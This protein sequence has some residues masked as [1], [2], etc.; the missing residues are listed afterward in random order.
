[1]SS[2]APSPAPAAPNA[3]ALDASVRLARLRKQMFAQVETPRIAQ[4]HVLRPLGGGGMGLVFAAWD[5]SLDRVI[6][7]KVLRD[8]RSAKSGKQL[9]REAIALA[10]LRHPNVVSVFEVGDHRG[11]VY[12]AMEYVEG[13][14][15][16]AWVR[17][18]RAARRRD[19]DALLDVFGQAC[20]G[21][22]AAHAADLVHRDVK[23][24][25]VMIDA[26]GRVRLMDFGLARRDAPDGATQDS[27]PIVSDAALA[28]PTLTNTVG[29]Q[30]TPAYMAPEQFDGDPPGPAADQFALCACLFEA[31]VGRSA[32]PDRMTAA[33]VAAETPVEFPS[34]W[35]GPR[36]LQAILQRGLAQDP[37]A[38]F[39]S[40]E[41]L[42]EQLARLRRRSTGRTVA[43]AGLGVGLVATITA[44]TW[45]SRA[46]SVDPCAHAGDA[47][48]TTYST[49]IGDGVAANLRAVDATLGGDAA[50]RVR[51]V[52]DDYATALTDDRIEACRATGRGEQ[53]DTLLDLRVACLDRHQ[54][55]L[56]AVVG[57]L[58]TATDVEMVERALDV[59]GALP[60]LAACADADR[61]RSR[62]AAPDD[63]VA[64]AEIEATLASTAQARADL[65]A[66]RVHPAAA[67]VPAL[68]ATAREL[69][70]APLLAEVLHLHAQIERD[71]RHSTSASEAFAEAFR[72]AVEGGLSVLARDAA[73]DLAATLGERPARFDE[74]QRWLQAAEGW[75]ARQPADDIPGA[76]AV[77]TARASMLL[78]ADR[79]Q[80]AADVASA[81]LADLQR[82]PDSI[83]SR[84]RRLDLLLLLGRIQLRR[85]KLADARQAF[86]D[87]L[88]LAG[89]A[90]GTDHPRLAAVLR[91]GTRVASA[92][93]DHARALDDAA[94]AESIIRATYGGSSIQLAGV[95]LTR[96]GAESAAG[97]IDDAIAT[98]EQALAIAE[99]A[100][101][102]SG[103]VRAS[104]MAQLSANLRQ[105]GQTARAQ[106]LAIASVAVF[107]EAYGPGSLDGARARLGVAAGLGIAHQYEEAL[108]QFEATRTSFIEYYGPIHHEIL[109][110][111]LN[112]ALA[113]RVLG[114]YR[115]AHAAL[116]RAETIAGQLDDD[117]EQ[118]TARIAASR[119]KVFDLQQLAPR[120]LAEG[121]RAMKLYEGLGLRSPEL[122]REAY[123]QARRLRDAG[124]AQEA[125]RLLKLTIAVCDERT[126]GG[127]LPIQARWV[128]R[129]LGTEDAATE[130]ELAVTAS[131]QLAAL[132]FQLDDAEIDAEIRR[133]ASRHGPPAKKRRGPE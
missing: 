78:E 60:D 11:Q 98:G 104:L 99:A 39:P 29:L 86:D 117:P 81:A 31:V 55:E 26:E 50:A 58:S 92:E 12:L 75:Q 109:L 33:A 73:A 111:E 112:I 119:A 107:D 118:T 9:R 85:S 115:R 128:L 25:N 27:A 96:A 130:Q 84:G 87:A 67:Q 18:W 30:G 127:S 113:A 77:A 21:L 32:R 5:P 133:W 108:E 106:E 43:L 45:V 19:L 66:G 114:D 74:A 36:R 44:A 24:E 23:P 97:R 62:I 80:D 7:I 14:T 16:R 120:A 56:D 72:Y 47:V 89:E 65:A 4:Y 82:A 53:S 59:V 121:S 42:A 2:L 6:A 100:G 70:Y 132:G 69:A 94:R 101:G 52:L 68:L 102:D 123:Q 28:S 110:V 116:A 105:V 22:A 125:A 90:Y 57:V 131:A 37:S 48:A 126:I 20:R 103:P 76:T 34:R 40:M 71:L 93:G 79:F 54:T 83:A 41:A 13:Q 61:L 51:P 49:E 38:R 63:A 122:A 88:T 10:R 64:A 46:T 95:L 124:D 15:L 8:P 3:D 35:P 129:E 17:T 91:A 1:M